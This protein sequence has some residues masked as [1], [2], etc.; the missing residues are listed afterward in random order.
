MTIDS[1]IKGYSDSPI[2]PS[3]ALNGVK[4]LPVYHKEILSPPE[5]DSEKH[6]TFGRY[7]C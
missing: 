3:V 6:F 7:R 2:F 5:A 1:T 4:G